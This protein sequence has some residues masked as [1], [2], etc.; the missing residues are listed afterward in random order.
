MQSWSEYFASHR[1]EH[2]ALRDLQRRGVL[3]LPP[4]IGVELLDVVRHRF[5][6]QGEQQALERATALQ[7]QLK[8]RIK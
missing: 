7:Q 6:E 2:R 1:E 3:P 4:A 8:R 5:R